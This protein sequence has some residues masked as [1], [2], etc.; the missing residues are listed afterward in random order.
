MDRNEDPALEILKAKIIELD[1]LIDSYT[2]DMERAEESFHSLRAMIDSLEEKKAGLVK[3][4]AKLM[5]E[6]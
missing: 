3:A 5:V 6:H 4:A 1:D 2:G